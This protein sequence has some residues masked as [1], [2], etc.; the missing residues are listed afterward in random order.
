MSRSVLFLAI[1]FLVAGCEAPP[2]FPVYG[3]LSLPSELGVFLLEDK[4]DGPCLRKG[5]LRSRAFLSEG[6]FIPAEYSFAGV[7]VWIHGTTFVNSEE[8]L[9]GQTYAHGSEV[10]VERYLRALAHEWFHSYRIRELGMSEW[11]EAEHRGW[12]GGTEAMQR[13]EQEMDGMECR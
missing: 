1:V 2:E 11:D 6:G 12:P 13:V 8:E 4:R 3:T 5:I 9:W 7:Q 10:H